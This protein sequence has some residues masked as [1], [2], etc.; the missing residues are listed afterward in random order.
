MDLLVLML[1]VLMVVATQL[2]VPPLTHPG[3]IDASDSLLRPVQHQ[4]GSQVGSVRGHNDHSEAGPHHAQNP[5]RE[6]A[7]G[8]CI[9][10]RGAHTSTMLSV[11]WGEGWRLWGGL[12]SPSP[13]PELSST[14]QE[15]HMAEDS[16]RASSSSSSLFTLNL[17]KGL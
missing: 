16:V 13:I 15:N 12:V 14:P 8:S 11:G 2:V 1:L 5:G 7:W 10:R 9:A 6:A 4:E 3:V 17:P